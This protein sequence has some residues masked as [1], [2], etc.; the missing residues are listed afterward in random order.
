MKKINVM[1]WFDLNPTDRKKKPLRNNGH[2][3]IIIAE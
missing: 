3:I 2:K 1:V